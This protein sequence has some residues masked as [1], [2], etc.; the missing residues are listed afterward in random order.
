M[1][2]SVRPVPKQ[3]YFANNG[4]PAAGYL[5]YTYSAG[6]LTPLATFSDEAGTATNPNPVVLDS[7]GEA[8]IHWVGSYKVDLKTPLGVSV[9][10]YPVDNYMDLTY[11]LSLPSGSGLVSHISAGVGAVL[12]DVQT[13]LRTLLVNVKDFGAPS[14]GVTDATT[15][16]NAAILAAQKF[17]ANQL[18]YDEIY[19]VRVLFE[20]GKDY[21]IV[22]PI[23]LP[24]G[25][26]LDGQGCRFIGA[27]SGAGAAAYNAALP[28]LIVSSYYDGTT[29]A[30]NL[31]SAE[32]TQRLVR[33]GVENIAFVNAN[34]VINAF[35]MTVG[36]FIKNCTISN[37]SRAFNLASCYYLGLDTV[38]I[39]G[40]A[41]SAN[42]PA[43]TLLTGNNNALTF[44]KVSVGGASVGLAVN[45]PANA[46]VSID[47][48]TFESSTGTGI[49]F[50]STSY[51]LGWNIFGGCYFEGVRYAIAT[52]A[53]AGVF[54]ICIDGNFFSSCEYALLA[55]PS[56]I[57]VGSW[58][59]N[60]CP[61]DGGVIRNLV[62]LSPV[63]NDIRYQLAGKTGNSTDGPSA[64]PSNITPS[65]V[66]IAE[67]SSTWQDTT[68][69]NSAIAKSLPGLANQNNLNEFAF[70]GAHIVSQGNQPPFCTLT[71]A[72]DT[73]T[74]DTELTYDLSN[75]LMFNYYGATDSI[76]YTL[77]G[78][79]FGTTVDWVTRDPVGC[80]LTVTSNASGNVRL[81]FTSLTAAVP[82]I[83]VSGAARHV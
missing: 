3:R 73:L 68:S 42:A 71:R 75:V 67:T 29:I 79:V 20:A 65:G 45:G 13:Q 81:T 72:V 63:G 53:G 19:S 76:N 5:L 11:K 35:N 25:V 15:Q 77:H 64:F 30:S 51:C 74:V 8:I 16:I 47:N 32:G 18:S 33:S 83:N 57:R 12:A 56:S 1:T 41:T 6:T 31:S 80:N 27:Y 48:C 40:S 28:S 69:P 2:T 10:G 82:I 7:K 54:G 36:C 70:E 37:V 23:L 17:K 34:C 55:A 21:K 44:R 9:T 59:G 60:A 22:G 66:S 14:D 39:T 58:R 78:W 46:G 49:F 50:G 62:D 26:I 4:T 24:S 61:D 52:E 38:R 43:I